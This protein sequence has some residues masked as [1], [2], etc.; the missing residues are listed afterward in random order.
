MKSV[1][2]GNSHIRSKNR[3]NSVAAHCAV[4][5]FSFRFTYVAVLQ[6]L[7]IGK[8]RQIADAH[9]ALN[10]RQRECLGYNPS[11]VVFDELRGVF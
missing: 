3:R 2:K 5:C 10:L 8:N 9:N 7:V 6:L 4:Q 11:A 1:S